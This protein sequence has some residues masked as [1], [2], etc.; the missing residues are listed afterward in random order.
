ML[1]AQTVQETV[2]SLSGDE[3]LARAK[4][5]FP[6]RP[7]LYAAFVDREGPG[8]ASFRGQG[9]EELV[10]AVSPAEGGTRVT[11]STY[12]FDMQVARFFATLPA[13]GVKS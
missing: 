1:S 2:T 3:V 12:L 6:S 7:S 9:T 4:T 11:G 5:F 8:F 10:I 13:A